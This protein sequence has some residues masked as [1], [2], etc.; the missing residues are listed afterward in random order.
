MKIGDGFKTHVQQ[1]NRVKKGQLLVEFDIAKIKAAGYPVITS[2]VVTNFAEYKDI[3]VPD[4]K[5]VSGGDNFI[6]TVV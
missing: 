6:T 1:G 4:A 5:K 2:V 3:V